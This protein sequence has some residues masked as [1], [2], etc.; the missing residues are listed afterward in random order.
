MKF[1]FPPESMFIFTGIPKAGLI[2]PNTGIDADY[3]AA[4]WTLVS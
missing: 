1:G 4:A 3:L 2:L